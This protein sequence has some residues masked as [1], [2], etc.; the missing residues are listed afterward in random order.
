MT[1]AVPSGF[2]WARKRAVAMA[3]VKTCSSSTSMP[4]PLQLGGHV[5][6]RALAVVGQEQK[7]NVALRQL[8]E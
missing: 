6:P 1:N 4:M 3:Q 7:G 8:V 5:A 2:C